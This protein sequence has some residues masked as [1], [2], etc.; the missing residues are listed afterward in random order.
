MVIV[1]S[2]MNNDITIMKIIIIVMI[3]IFFNVIFVGNIHLYSKT[4]KYSFLGA[5]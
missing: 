4:Y 2:N 1:V 5:K 3:I